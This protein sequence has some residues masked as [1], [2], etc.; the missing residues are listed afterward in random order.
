V[1]PVGSGSWR[2]PATEE[3][4]TSLAPP[5]I[6]R[7]RT[8]HLCIEILELAAGRGAGCARLASRRSRGPD[9]LISEASVSSVFA[10]SGKA[11]VAQLSGANLRSRG[12]SVHSR[13]GERRQKKKD[14]I[15]KWLGVIERAESASLKLF[16]PDP[17][18]GSG[19]PS[20]QSAKGTSDKAP[21]IISH[22]AA[23]EPPSFSL[24]RHGRCVMF[25]T[26]QYA[27]VPWRSVG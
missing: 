3:S 10:F 27:R 9:W 22:F 14:E 16:M 8:R 5:F 25:Y 21:S 2:G 26:V 4:T 20:P 1:G 6:Y 24:P 7:Q 13:G 12:K 19:P 11:F 18:G 17:T 15:R 23:F